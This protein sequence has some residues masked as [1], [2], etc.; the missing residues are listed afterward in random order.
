L[1]NATNVTNETNETNERKEVFPP[2][3]KEGC[4]TKP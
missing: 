4:P 1:T 2:K 3:K